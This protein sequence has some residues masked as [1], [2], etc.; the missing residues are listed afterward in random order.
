MNNPFQLPNKT[1]KTIFRFNKDVTRVIIDMI[2]PYLQQGP[3]IT[4]VPL[5]LKFLASLHFYAT[6][7]YQLTSAHDYNFA[8]SQPTMS[9]CLDQ[10]TN[11]IY[12]HLLTNWIKF[13]QTQN[14]KNKVVEGF[15]DKFNMPRCLGVIDCT[16][17][18]II[19]PPE[20]YPAILL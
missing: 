6:G 7:G 20:N 13:P 2:R 1:F 9:R 18:A 5:E 12:D 14:A 4:A 16:H 3:R 10:V 17:I 19:S 8:I 11:V 15:M